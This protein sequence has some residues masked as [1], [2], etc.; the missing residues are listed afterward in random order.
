MNAAFIVEE[1]RRAGGT[2]RRASGDVHAFACLYAGGGGG[3]S[4][5]R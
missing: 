4:Q 5:G 1:V 3:K 2:E